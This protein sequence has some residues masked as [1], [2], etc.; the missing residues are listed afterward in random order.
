MSE[1]IGRLDSLGVCASEIAAIIG[2][3]TNYVTAYLSRRKGIDDRK[4]R[5]KA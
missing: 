4:K 5:G 2:K 1:R 3:K